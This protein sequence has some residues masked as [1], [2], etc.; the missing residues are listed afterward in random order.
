MFPERFDGF[1]HFDLPRGGISVTPGQP[2]TMLVQDTGKVVF[3][4]KYVNGNSSTAG[5]AYF[6][7]APFSDND[8]LFKTYG[9]CSR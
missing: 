4:W 1:W 7:N 6:Y 5:Q 3:W 2:I 9:V 8:F